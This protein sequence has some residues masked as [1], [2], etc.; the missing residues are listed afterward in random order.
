MTSTQVH[1][2]ICFLHPGKTGGTYLKSVIRHNES[3][4]TQPIMLM[5]HRASL[6]STRNEFGP[7]RKLAF[8]YRDPVDRFVSAFQSRRRQ[9]RPTY[10]RNWSPGEAISFM[11]FETASSLAEALDSSD[12]RLKSAAL[13]AFKAIMH[14]KKDYQFHF[15]NLSILADE[16]PNILACLDVAQ[17]DQK[18]PLF[19]DRIGISDVEMPPAADVHANP[20]T[21]EML[22][23]HA[24]RNLKAY[25]E[26]EF[27]FFDAFKEIEASLLG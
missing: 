27:A 12:E 21:P 9:G 7:D 17:I 26:V 1:S 23:E 16:L 22:S 10:N 11:Y 14:I 20:E 2:A 25:W 15:G 18:L 5:S 24:L 13:F 6:K 8:T 19:L 3:N 4:W